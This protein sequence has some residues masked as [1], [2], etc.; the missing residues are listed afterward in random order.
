MNNLGN[1]SQVTEL[2]NSRSGI[3]TGQLAYLFQ[4]KNTLLQ[5][6]SMILFLWS[7]LCYFRESTQGLHLRK[8]STLGSLTPVCEKTT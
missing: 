7:M 6:I 5:T 4:T 1:F 3:L 2:I 8:G